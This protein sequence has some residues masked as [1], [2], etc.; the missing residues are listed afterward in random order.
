MAEQQ[1]T[2]KACPKCGSKR[3]KF[4]RSQSSARSSGEGLAG[5]F[6][7]R[8]RICKDCGTQYTPTMP[9]WLPCVVIFLGVILALVGLMAFFEP[10]MKGPTQF[11]GWVKYAF[12]LAG[13]VFIAAGV[14]LFRKKGA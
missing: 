12:I 14:Q 11:R 5:L 2:S 4:A 9:R 10:L 8:D 7:M 1:Q 6:A 3:F 13:L